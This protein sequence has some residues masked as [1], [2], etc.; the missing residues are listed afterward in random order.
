M[1]KS[2]NYN[3]NKPD[4]ADQY[5][6]KHWNQN[7]DMLDSILKEQKDSLDT[8]VKTRS[9]SDNEMATTISNILTGKNIVEKANKDADGNIINNTYQTKANKVNS[10]SSPT[11]NDKYPSEK[12][13]KDTLDELK[14]DITKGAINGIKVN[15]KALSKDGTSVNFKIKISDGTNVGAIANLN[16]AGE[17]IIQLPTKI[18]GAV[19]N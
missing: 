3:F 8:E 2:I 12:L 1:K 9:A 4:Y 13:V 16:D 19:F 17:I 15:D 14:D 7:T 6:L 18:Y 5:D 10:W 11:S